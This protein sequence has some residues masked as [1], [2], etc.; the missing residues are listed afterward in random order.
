[1]GNYLYGPM[2]EAF[3]RT[4][5]S[6]YLNACKV[7][8][9]GRDDRTVQGET[10]VE[11]PDTGRYNRYFDVTDVTEQAIQTAYRHQFP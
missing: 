3:E 5:R 6:R 1:L 2:R 7:L 8:K 10:S 9:E 4:I 11:E